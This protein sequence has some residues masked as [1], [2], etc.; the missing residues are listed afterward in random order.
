MCLSCVRAPFFEKVKEGACEV[1]NTTEDYICCK[2]RA[3]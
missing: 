2:L 3:S 1:F